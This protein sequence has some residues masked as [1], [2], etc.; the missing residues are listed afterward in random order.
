[1]P[2]RGISVGFL[3]KEALNDNFFGF[4]FIHSEGHELNQL[5]IIDSADCRFVN[6]LCIG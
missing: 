3:F 1:M 6:N 5:V 4:F 2:A